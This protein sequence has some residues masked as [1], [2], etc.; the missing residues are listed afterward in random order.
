MS[1]HGQETLSVGRKPKSGYSAATSPALNSLL[2]KNNQ[3][4]RQN[5]HQRAHNALA[6]PALDLLLAADNLLLSS[7]QSA[8]VSATNVQNHK[9]RCLLVAKEVHQE[10]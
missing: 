9:H 5:K 4:T 10:A 8:D 3:L 2:I 1:Y 6:S 7:H